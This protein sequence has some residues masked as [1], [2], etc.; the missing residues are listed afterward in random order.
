MRKLLTVML[1]LGV[2]ALTAQAQECCVKIEAFAGYSY[3]NAS[4]KTDR[5]PPDPNSNPGIFDGRIGQHGFGV[6]IAGRIKGKLGIVGDFS[7]QSADEKVFNLNTDTSTLVFLA[8]PRLSIRNQETTLFAQALMGGIRRKV[9]NINLHIT[10]TDLALG[11]G[12]GLDIGFKK[13]VA[14]RAFEFDYLPSRGSD[15]LPNIG[16][17]WSQNFRAQ[18]GFV[19]RFGD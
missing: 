8:G 17:R 3:F 15:A 10:A 16:K 5:I 13:H 2:P 7:F 4:P 9:D 19:F 14:F 18:I 6:N 11:F 12:G 1:L